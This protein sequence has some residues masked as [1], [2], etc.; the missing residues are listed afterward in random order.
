[1]TDSDLEIVFFELCEAA[2]LPLPEL[3]AEV[4]G[5]TVDALWRQERLVV[6]IDGPGNHRTPAQIRRDRRKE[7]DLR[8]A[9]FTILRY[10]DEQVERQRSAISAE[11]RRALA[12]P[13]TA[14]G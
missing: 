6:E 3:N 11:I 7:L 9:A 13:L 14:A 1:M 10:S 4:V 5:W 2:D 12:S 8:T